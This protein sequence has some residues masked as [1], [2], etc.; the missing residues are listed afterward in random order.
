MGDHR[1]V[2]VYKASAEGVSQFR[3]LTSWTSSRALAERYTSPQFAGF[4]GPR[5]YATTTVGASLDLR[6]NAAGLLADLGFDLEDYGEEPLHD[7][8]RV[9]A[10]ALLVHGVRWVGFCEDPTDPSHDEWLYVGT[11][12]IAAQVADRP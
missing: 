5:L 7:V 12:P 10:P 1:R 6:T 3:G 8:L 11:E 9:I 2:L 4:G